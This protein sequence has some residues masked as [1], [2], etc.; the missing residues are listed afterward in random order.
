MKVNVLLTPSNL[1]ELS[2]SGKTTIVIDVL[3]ATSTIVN[4][5]N[6]GAKEIIASMTSA[7]GLV[8][9]FAQAIE[10]IKRVF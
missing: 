8:S 6:N 4:A 3:R 9:G 5:L 10:V 7:V 1:D 2:F